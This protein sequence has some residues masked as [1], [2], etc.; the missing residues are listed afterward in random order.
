MA[1]RG[2]G[3]GGNGSERRRILVADDEPI[4]LELVRTVLEEDGL[5]ATACASAD[6]VTRALAAGPFDAVV[7][8]LR[9]PG[10]DAIAL[11]RRLA[12]ARNPLA[13]RMI[14]ITGDVI[15]ERVDRFARDTGNQTLQKP[16]ALADLRDA[17]TKALP[18]PLPAV[19]SPR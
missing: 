5:E 11:H 9:L 7:V 17:V 12:Q 10:M 3:V 1:E 14:V 16:F 8:D 15:D 13:R 2:T 19:P 18:T 4:V 6:D